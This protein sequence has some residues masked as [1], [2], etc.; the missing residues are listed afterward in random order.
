MPKLFE[1][2]NDE[3]RGRHLVAASRI[4][5]GRLVLC[6]RPLL[7]QQNLTNVRDAWVCHNCSAF[8]G[9]A[10][11]AMLHRFGEGSGEGGGGISDGAEAC[12]STDSP[13]VSSGVGVLVPCRH[14]CGHAY[15]SSE[16]ERDAYEAHHRWLCTGT[17]EGPDHPLVRFKAFAAETNEI[18]LAAAQ[19]WVVQHVTARKRTT[20]RGNDDAD[21]ADDNDTEDVHNAYTDFVMEPWW[22][23][24][25]L[26][27]L[28]SKD[29]GGFAEAIQ[30]QQAQRE[31]CEQAAALL[32][33]ALA[34]AAAAA[35]RESDR[36]VSIPPVTAL[37]IAR[38]LGSFSQNAIGF[39]SRHPLCREVFDPDFRKR[40]HHEIVVALEEAGFLGDCQDE[41]E[42]DDE[43][44]SDGASDVEEAAVAEP[45]ADDGDGTQDPPTPQD[46][47]VLLSGLFVDED[48][49]V[50]ETNQTNPPSNE[51]IGAVEP[52][53]Q[54]VRDTTGDDLDYIFPPLDGTALYSTTCKMNHSCNPN[55]IVLFKRRS[56]GRLH[57]LVAH[58]VALRD[59]AEGEELTI[60]YIE[61]D[62][63]YDERQL[64]LAS[65]GFTCR[66]TK[67]ERES[68]SQN[69]SAAFIRKTISPEEN[70]FGSD[71]DEEAI[72]VPS[73][74]GGESSDDADEEEM[75]GERELEQ[76]LE[77][78]ESR[79]N[80]SQFGSLPLSMAARVFS[81]IIQSGSLLLEE[82]EKTKDLDSDVVSR[83]LSRCLDGARERDYC[84]CRVSGSDLESLLF[85]ELRSRGSFSR[86][87]HR[88]A[89]W[90]SVLAAAVGFAHE[91]SF[92]EA[93][94]LLDKGLI[95]GLQRDNHSLHPFVEYVEFHASQMAVGPLPPS[96]SVTIPKHQSTEQ[97]R[98][99]TNYG[100]ACPLGNK[101]DE[102]RLP[103]S[104]DEFHG[105]F[106]KTSR[107]VVVRDYAS[108]WKALDSM[109]NLRQLVHRHG[110]RLLPIEIGCMLKRSSAESNATA[111]R[112][113][114]MTLRVFVE[115]FLV[116]STDHGIW[117]LVDATD[118]PTKRVAYMAQHALLT[119]IPDLGRDLVLLPDLC[120]PSGPDRVNAWVGTG[121]TRTPL[122]FDNYDNLLVQLVGVKYVRLYAA[123]ATDKLPRFS[124]SGENSSY[125]RQG[126]MSSL[127]CELEE[128][129]EALSGVEE[130]SAMYTEALLFPGDCLFIPS[131]VWH[132]VRSLSTSVSVNY[133]FDNP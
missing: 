73:A 66:C 132:Y 123:D 94:A 113:E 69:Q 115:S 87:D 2:R 100:L 75:R 65:Y 13:A 110:H 5:K 107:P 89:Y 36:S 40:W 42:D 58:C 6:E 106:L 12:G 47:V 112:E 122:H 131:R 111:M 19:W 64:A 120:G 29:P 98:A 85:H 35:E 4:E 7:G 116:A 11:D 109:R 81:F 54:R 74:A 133:W 10:N 128:I 21:A 83:T 59:I 72:A 104:F 28:T 26:D 52:G 126:N 60:S 53:S 80:H 92:V 43:D 127:N 88:E 44:D 84:L 51:D 56:F 41:D 45:E 105:E 3:I 57:P 124:V 15:C 97:T 103:M 20:K 102:R 125:G 77:R 27:L 39:R 99:A 49:T 121:G 129:D 46:V 9:D 76:L 118:D 38:R 119:Q 79:S 24:S 67:C 62:R 32:N 14:S 61:N 23:V 31:I 34:A 33:E 8:I 71:D 68:S 30:I 130:A 1:R 50:L 95:L 48:G 70:L 114:L 91:G 82:L 78:L 17:A 101:I 96:V 55:M 117:S 37:D 90:C 18:L 108:C 93:L 25:V 22:D 16:C 86:V 63:P